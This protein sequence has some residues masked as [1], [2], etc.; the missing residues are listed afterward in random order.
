MLVSRV[1][2]TIEYRGVRRELHV[3]R[4]ADGT[5]GPQGITRSSASAS[6]APRR[7][8]RY[9]LADALLEKR[10]W[11]EPGANT[12]Y[13]RLSDGAGRGSAWR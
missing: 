9:A 11:M 8:G 6:T 1:E 12:T 13:V 7:C 4:W 5:L 3:N 10:V 2:E